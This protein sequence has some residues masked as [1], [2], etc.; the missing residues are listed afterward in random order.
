MLYF[1]VMKTFAD[2]VIH[3]NR[4]LEFKGP[5]PD[6]IRIMN[7]FREDKNVNAIASVFYK[8]YYNDL[9]QRRIVLGINP[10]RF[11]GGITGIPFTDPK[12]LVEKCGIPFHG[13]PAHEPSSVFIYEMID[14]FGGP[15]SF[16]K[17]LYI[18]SICPLGFTSVKPG[19]KEVNY[20]YYDS[21]ELTGAVYDFINKSIRKQIA[22]GIDTELAFCFGTGK[23]EK[24]L[25]ALNEEKKY[26]NRIIA[27][28]HP[29]F[30]MQYKSKQKAIYINKYISAF[31]SLNAV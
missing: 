8:K 1:C 19:G 3:F 28:E 21:K 6:G 31:S 18:N 12:R 16:Y 15:A 29:R 14:A 17:E 20:N 30:I 22:F 13:Q 11:G 26:F 2:K 27:L 25:R 5:L 9:S 24:F 7:P 10:G 4:Q 23:N